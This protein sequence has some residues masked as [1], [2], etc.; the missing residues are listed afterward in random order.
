MR[1]LIT[2]NFLPGIAWFFIV[3]VLLFMPGGGLPKADDWMKKIYFDKIVHIGLFAFMGYLFCMPLLVR[4]RAKFT[5][6]VIVIGSFWGFCSEIIQHY[7]NTGRS[8]DIID[9]LSDTLGLIIGYFSAKYFY[10][11]LYN[12]K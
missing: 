1:F 10:R 8:F 12:V 9:W 6:W 11:K 2:R 7:S 5:T 3:A 4:Q